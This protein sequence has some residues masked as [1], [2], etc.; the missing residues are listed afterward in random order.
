MARRPAA[1]ARDHILDTAADLFD[2][3][4]VH[5]VGL[6]QIIDNY[7]CG[8]NMF[9]REFASKD[10]LVVAYL[11]RCTEHWAGIVGTA[12]EQHPEDDAAQLLAIVRAVAA[13]A[14][15]TRNRGCALR[16]AL[17]EFPEPGHPAHGVAVDH[18]TAVRA[19]LHDLANR[20]EAREPAIL[21]DRLMLII[22]GLY[23]NGAT[24]GSAGAA[25][26]AVAFAEDVLAVAT[27]QPFR[28]QHGRQ[29]HDQRAQLG[30]D[31]AAAS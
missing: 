10:E 20:T 3:H 30:G 15:V 19:Q 18:F 4:G 1:N 21:A 8:K 31:R 13:D 2:A 25:P 16:N 5:A 17:A 23:A 29:D 9:Y 11:R 22:D 6:Q 7:G 27:G 12:A 24:L 26:A 28:D 14:T